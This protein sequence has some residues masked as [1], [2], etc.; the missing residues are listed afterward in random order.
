MKNYATGHMSYILIFIV[1]FLK[2]H[3]T[4]IYKSDLF[5]KIN[6]MESLIMPVSEKYFSSF[7]NKFDLPTTSSF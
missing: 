4:G 1:V 7:T 5:T 2:L 6:N 3:V